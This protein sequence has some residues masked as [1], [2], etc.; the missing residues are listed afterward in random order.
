MGGD[1]TTDNTKTYSEH[2]PFCDSEDIIMIGDPE[3]ND[4]WVCEDCDRT[5]G[6]FKMKI[7]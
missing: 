4:E 5:F 7:N 6:S 2:C 3:Y 1:N